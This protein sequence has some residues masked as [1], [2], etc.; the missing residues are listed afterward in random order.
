MTTDLTAVESPRVEIL[1]CTEK[2]LR[3]HLDSLFSVERLVAL[4]PAT[5]FSQDH[6]QSE[7]VERV[8]IHY[9]NRAAV[10]LDAELART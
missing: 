5:E 9:E 7:Q 1:R 6:L 3:D 4:D 8:V 2:V 10:L